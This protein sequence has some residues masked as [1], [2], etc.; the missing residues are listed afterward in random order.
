MEELRTLGIKRIELLT[1][2]HA[3]AA[4]GLAQTLGIPFQAGLLP[5][6]KIAVVRAAQA[7]GEVVVMIGDGVNDAP[8]LAQADIGIAMGAG[9]APLPARQPGLCFYGMTGCW[10]HVFSAPPN[11]P[12][13]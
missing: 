8:A 13:V 6:D 3:Q 9:A 1:G 2:D 7:A 5:E 12:C 4:A 10:W 11:A